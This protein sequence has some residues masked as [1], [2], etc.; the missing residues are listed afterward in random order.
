M[1]N[2]IVFAIFVIQTKQTKVKSGNILSISLQIE[3]KNYFEKLNSVKIKLSIG[4]TYVM[5]EQ[6][7]FGNTVFCRFK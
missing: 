5:I 1:L 2:V 7:N 3:V 4:G 6:T